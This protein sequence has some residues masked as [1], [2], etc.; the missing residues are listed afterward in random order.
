MAR[1]PF[2]VPFRS[3]RPSMVGINYTKVRRF[4][5]WR[6]SFV[7]TV[8]MKFFHFGSNFGQAFINGE[9][10]EGTVLQLGYCNMTFKLCESVLGFVILPQCL[11]GIILSTI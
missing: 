10:S 5:L 4:C 2:P 7:V 1:L 11:E 3:A 6:V 8:S 9:Y